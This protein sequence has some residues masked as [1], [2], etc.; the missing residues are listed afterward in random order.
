MDYPRV[1]LEY[2][3]KCL[4]RLKLYY[5]SG[6][7]FGLRGKELLTYDDNPK[8]YCFRAVLQ[9]Q[10]INLQKKTAFATKKDNLKIS[11]IKCSE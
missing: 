3:N 6:Y 9:K 7:D 4:N 11:K 10:I 5:L 2:F 1:N 8:L